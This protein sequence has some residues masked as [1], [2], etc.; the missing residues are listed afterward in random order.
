MGIKTKLYV[1]KIFDNNLFAISKTKISL[2]LNKPAYVGMSMLGLSKVLMHE[3]HYNSIKDKYD[4]KSK[5]LFTDNGSLKHEI[6]TKDFYG[7]FSRDKKIFDYSN[8]STQS[9][10]YDNYNKLVPGKMKDETAGDPIKEFVGL[11]P[12]MYSFLVDDISENKK[13]NNL[14]KHVAAIISRNVSKDILR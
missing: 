14:N 9:K 5:L 7:D 11:K 8:Y 1:Y 12:K 10:F 13:E 6:K 4:S 2:T 3:V